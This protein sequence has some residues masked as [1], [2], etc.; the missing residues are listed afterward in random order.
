M[1]IAKTINNLLSQR[2]VDLKTQCWANAQ[3]SRRECLEFVGI[4]SLRMT[5]PWKKRL[6]KFSKKLVAT[7]ILPTLKRVIVLPKG[8]TE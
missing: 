8:M 5:T 7:L 3:Y 2:V 6:F 4:A 1:K